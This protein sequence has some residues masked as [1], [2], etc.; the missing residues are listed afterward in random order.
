MKI[1][2]FG[3]SRCARSDGEVARNA[4]LPSKFSRGPSEEAAIAAD[5]GRQKASGQSGTCQCAR[6]VYREK[7]LSEE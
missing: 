1:H 7:K 4:V 6:S 3:K 5:S 2:I